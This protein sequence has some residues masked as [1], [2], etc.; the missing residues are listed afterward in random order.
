[1][2]TRTFTHLVCTVA[3]ATGAFL[4]Q[5]ANAQVKPDV[6]EKIKAAL[7]M[8][9]SAKPKSPRKV[10][11]FS[12]T[13]GFRH[14]SIATGAVSLAMLGKA[15][16][17]YTAV[18]SED[19]SMFEPETLKQFDAV[20]M[21]NTTGELFRPRK[22]PSDPEEKKKALE[23]EERLKQSLVDFV[24]SGKGLAGTHSAT[25]TYK[26]W[27]DYNDMMGGAFAGHPWHQDV[28]VRNLSADHP[29][30]AAFAGEGFTVKD[31]IY[32][33]RDD[34]ALKSD[35]LMLLSLDGEKMD[36]GRGKRTD[37]FYPV[38]WVSKYG[39]GRTFYCSLGHRDEIY[40]NPAVLKHY[41]AGFQYAL[42]D[43]EADATP[44][45]N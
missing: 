27:K 23:R 24:K 2:N 16:G 34:T 3:I 18:H 17:A 33:F 15:T 37:G 14:G 36:L 22:L 1:M 25:D 35:R 31:E 44:N 26:K 10:L 40:Y 9:A 41:L 20:I 7:P 11:I 32:Q 19:D 12:K 13:N 4:V 29:I 43:L 8:E 42:G 45:S 21:L 39:K 6:I 38:S 28:P 5:T 30:N